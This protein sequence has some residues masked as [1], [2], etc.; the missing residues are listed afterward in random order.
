MLIKRISTKAF[1]IN[2]LIA[3]AVFA[4]QKFV[5]SWDAG[6]EPDLS[7]YKVYRSTSPNASNQ[8]G[9]VNHPTT[10]YSDLSIEKGVL[11]YYRVKAVDNAFNASDFSTEL[12]A[13]YPKIDN[14][15]SSFQVNA[16]ASIV[17]TLDN[18]VSDPDN[19]DESLNWTITGA[20]TLSV[21]ITERIAT[22]VAPVTWSGEESLEFKVEDSQGFSDT[23]SVIFRAEE[24]VDTAPVISNIPDQQL[25]EDGQLII[26]FYPQ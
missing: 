16:L 17:I 20:N 3:S 14:L 25:N 23:K 19:S 13:A 2:L 21:T 6:T 1:I 8:V 7:T 11:Y 9:S 24:V 5:I 26:N 12:S 4:Q 18:V 22:I 10:S 15:N